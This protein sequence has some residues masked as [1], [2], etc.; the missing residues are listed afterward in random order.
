MF[1]FSPRTAGAAVAAGALGLSAWAA[2]VALAHDAVIGGTVTEGQVLDEFPETITL[3]F[4][5]IPREGFNN[6]AVTNEETGDVLFSAEP[7]LDERNLTIETPDDVDPG[8]GDY[9]VG[10]QITSSDGH[11]TRGGVSFTVAGDDDSSVAVDE[12]AVPSPDEEVGGA[13]GPLKWI[14]AV[15]G[16][17]VLAAVVVLVLAKRRPI[18]EQ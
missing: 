3:E 15:G 10:F 7:E 1:S 8:P 12:S 13:D 18:D 16:V 4:S 11:A 6:F 9:Q 5:G 17:L 2:P 14:L